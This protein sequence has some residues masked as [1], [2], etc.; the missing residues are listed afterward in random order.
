[1]DIGTEVRIARSARLDTT[2]PRGIH[3]GD[4][5]AVSF[6]AAILSHDFVNYKHVETRIGSHCL[7]GARSVILPGVTIGN[8]CIIGA[9]SVVVADVP[10]GSLMSGNPARAVERN[11]RTGKWGIR[12]VH[13]LD[14]ANSGASTTSGI[15]TTRA[16]PLGERSVP[17]A[18]RANSL[19][20]LLALK[21][22]DKI[23]SLASVGFD[24]FGLVTLRAEIEATLGTIIDDDRWTSISTPADILAMLPAGTAPA[25]PVSTAPALPAS[26][27]PALSAASA[28]ALMPGLR[29]A[30]LPRTGSRRLRR[31]DVGMPQMI[32]AG[33]SESWLFKELG[34]IHWQILTDSL[35][36]SSRNIADARGD[37][38][39]ATFTAIRL[40]LGQPLSAI[41]ENDR[42]DIDM[43]MSR[44]GSGMFFS[45]ASIATQRAQGIVEIMS[46]FSKFEVPGQNTSLV[47]GQPAIPEN[48]AIPLLAAAPEIVDDYR[49]QRSDGAVE[50]ILFETEYELQPY[51]DINGVGLLYFAA[52]PIIN[53]VCAR[54]HLGASD[55]QNYTTL[56]RDTYY[57]A[58]S[59]AGGTI[60]FRIHAITQDGDKRTVSTS[61]SRAS[62]GK[63]MA[64]L[65]T[66]H[67]RLGS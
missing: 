53:D 30:D 45:T 21:N 19:D 9:G 14:R 22:E 51:H 16:L 24:S 18:A 44:F 62:D 63:L 20:Q 35:G 43:T 67:Q 60:I 42:L 6:D 66:T 31:H 12:A 52:Y 58:N 28:P 7:I 2:N 3:I 55:W 65:N 64:K 50:T 47:R 54:R 61:L 23:R 15:A 29:T 57:F 27:G 38:L 17:S 1:M 11:I 59:G 34:D 36:V 5:T 10:E 13:F 26:T 32:A 25:L 40:R 48:F 4:Y 49:T 8:H 39:Y 56:D 46:N 41:V 37:R 33:L